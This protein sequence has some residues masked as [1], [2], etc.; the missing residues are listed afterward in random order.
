MDN[1]GTQ[2]QAQPRLNIELEQLDRALVRLG[3]RLGDLMTKLHP[4][5]RLADPAP[6]ANGTPL[7]A[8]IA[9][10]GSLVPLAGV[11]LDRRIKVQL[12]TI[13]V[14]AIIDLIDL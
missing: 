10:T 14:D 3:E 13:K 4:V 12:L 1:V 5:M 7:V 2:P 9:G 11:I 6:E 8:D